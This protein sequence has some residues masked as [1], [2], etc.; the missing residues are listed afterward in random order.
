MGNVVYT[1]DFKF[2]HTPVLGNITQ[3]DLLADVGREGV[4]VALSDST[5]AERQGYT[6]SEKEVETLNE[7]FYRQ[8]EGL[9]LLPL[10]PMSTASNKLLM[11]P[12]LPAGKLPLMA[13]AW[14][15]L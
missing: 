4:L 8:K 3:F 6:H 14:L 5:N 9:S 7:I 11:P 12:A 15:M 1:S 10:P 13:G 2:D